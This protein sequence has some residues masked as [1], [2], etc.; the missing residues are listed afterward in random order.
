MVGGERGKGCE[1]CGGRRR[2]WGGSERG[3]RRGK[4]VLGDD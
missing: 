4:R 1:E 2:R 3:R